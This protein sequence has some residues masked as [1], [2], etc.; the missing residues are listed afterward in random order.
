MEKYLRFGH[1]EHFARFSLTDGNALYTAAEYFRKIKRIVEYK[2]NCRRNKAACFT[3]S[4][5]IVFKNKS[6]KIVN[7]KKASMCINPYMT[8]TW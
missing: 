1:A 7:N 6:G 4:P 8:G 5:Y 2:S 3:A